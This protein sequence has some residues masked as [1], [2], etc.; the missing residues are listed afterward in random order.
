MATILAILNALQV[1]TFRQGGITEARR[2][3]YRNL[4]VGQIGHVYEGLLDHGCRVAE[5]AVLGLIGKKGDEPEVGLRVLEAEKAKGDQA[6]GE[7]LAERGG[8]AAS[9][10]VQLLYEEFEPDADHRLR[11][12][13]DNDEAIFSRVR[14]FAG[15]LRRDLRDL[16]MVFLPGSLYVTQTSLRRDSGTAYTTEELADEV[17]QYA[18]EPAVYLPGPAEGAA[19]EDWVLR[20]PSEILRLKVCDPAVGSGAILVAACRYLADRLVEAWQAESPGQ[21]GLTKRPE[22]LPVEDWT[23][24]AQRLVLDHCLYGVDRNPMAVEMAKLSLWLTTLARERP[25]T[26]L[27]HQLRC[28]DSLLG[29][30]HLDQ[31]RFFHIDPERGKE[32]PPVFGTVNVI[33]ERVDAALRVAGELSAIDVV[34]LR[35]AERKARLHAEMVGALRPLGTV[36]DLVIGAALSASEGAERPRGPRAAARGAHEDIGERLV[37][38][39]ADVTRA[40]DAAVPLELQTNALAALSDTAVY[41]LDTDRPAGAPERQPL[42][43]PLA[44]PEVFLRDGRQ[45]F[46]AVVGNPPFLGGQRIT[47]TIGTR[48]RNYLVERV[49]GGQ[50]GSADLVAYFFLRAVSLLREN[51]GFGLLATNTIAQGDTREVGIGQIVAAGG[52]IIR[53]VPSE[54]WPGTANLEVAKVWVWRGQWLGLRVLSGQAVAGITAFLAVPGRVQGTPHRL[55]ANENN[56]FQGSI[57]LGMGFVMTPEEAQALIAKDPKN[58]DVLFPYLNGE[59]LNSR[60]DQSPSRWVINFKDWPLDRSSDGSWAGADEDKIKAWLRSGRLP[61]DYPKPVAADYPDCLDIV[62]RLVRPERQRPGA[63][64]GYQLRSP[65]PQR[66]W[67]YAEKRPELYSTIADMARVLVCSEVTHHLCFAWVPNQSVLSSNLDVFSVQSTGEFAALQSSLHDLWARTY[68]S[69]LVTRLKYSPGNAFETLPL[70]TRIDRL[71]DI[72]VRYDDHRRSVM[73]SRREG[74]TRTYNRFH[75]PAES[76]ADIVRLRE[77][78]VEM[79]RAVASAYGWTDLALGHGFHETKQ[80]LRYTVSPVAR[81]EILDRLLELNHQRYAEEVAAGLHPKVGVKAGGGGRAPAGKRLE[82][83]TRKPRKTEPPVGLF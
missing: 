36:A 51:A 44:F 24:H 72:G 16:P 45:G 73:T 37:S 5:D 49:A 15:L 32:R 56:S 58:R 3:S 78:H 34:T 75:D 63:K 71:D 33:E 82:S 81:Q 21:A 18:L 77:L 53:A 26:F 8:P 68:S 59:D 39:A 14:P 28:G 79:D 52:T 61:A 57:V 6:F 9:R 54:T 13:C 64:G 27:D 10:T 65:L 20:S 83:G 60:W 31:V 43:W 69:H 7:W 47:G 35:D 40:F 70:P 50:R 25:F 19:P 22:H 11:A 4:S 23:L 17:V 66:W 1:L 46:D 62:E 48:Y 55:K 2:L 74:L 76:A 30:T 67:H 38:V 42:H 12:A 41:W 29:I 80:G